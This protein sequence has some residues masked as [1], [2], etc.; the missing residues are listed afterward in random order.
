MKLRV[1]LVG[2]GD[3]WES[4]HRP[5]LISL[6]D[7]FE[8]RAVCSEVAALAEQAARDFDAVA[9]DGFRALSC[10]SDIDAVLVLAPDWYG[11]LPVLAACDSGKAVYCAP[12]LDIASDQAQR[13][14]QRVEE[15][16]IAFMA[17]FPRRYAPA[18]IRLKELIATHLGPP[19]LLFC[20]AR[21]KR[22]ANL[23]RRNSHT[24]SGPTRDMMEL[25]DW[26]RYT[27][28]REPASVIGIQHQEAGPKEPP[29]QGE[30]KRA[31]SRSDYQMM[32]LD[33][34]EPLCTG[35]G[36]LAHVSCGSYLSES[37][38]EAL[39]FRPPAELQVCCEQGVAFVDLPA[40]V[41][42]FDVAGRHH[43]T[44]DADRPVG[45][46]LLTQFHRAVT[47]LVRKTTDLED[48]YKTLSIVLAARESFAK[49]QRV[50][51][52]PES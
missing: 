50:Y 30:G 40:T 34:S 25:V 37:W 21:R 17:E 4:R 19:R 28:G 46:Q 9:V 24:I 6:R 43:E 38:P 47:S 2:L 15:S 35:K 10:R 18:T 29:P 48:A 33:F 26:C 16:G 32:S 36:P 20:H 44:L 39:S 31:R 23:K 1:G 45:E 51:L 12:A 41:T 22:S 52:R 14:R 5:A 27:V 42:W 11:P 3:H 7:R 8:V 49:G 13:I